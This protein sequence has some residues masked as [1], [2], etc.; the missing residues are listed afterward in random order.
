M[1]C[2]LHAAVRCGINESQRL[3]QLCRTITRPAQDRGTR[4]DQQ[5]HSGGAQAQHALARRQ[6]APLAVGAGVHAAH[7]P[8]CG[9]ELKMIAAIL[10]ASG[11]ERI[12]T[13]LGPP[14]ATARADFQRA[15]CWPPGGLA[16]REHE[17]ALIRVPWGNATASLCQ[18]PPTAMVASACRPAAAATQS[19]GHA[20]CVWPHPPRRARARVA[21]LPWQ[22]RA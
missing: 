15:A 16:Y 7:C 10:E 19:A 2:S 4:A 1:A 21:G 13:R 20:A 6:H 18:H 14:R 11:P 9:G 12:L 22:Y 3:E 8:N 17:Q 5:R